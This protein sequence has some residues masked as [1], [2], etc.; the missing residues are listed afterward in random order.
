V[1]DQKHLA[2]LNSIGGQYG[3]ELSELD[4]AGTYFDLK[5]RKVTVNG[6]YHYMCTRNNNFSNRSQKG[7]IVVSNSVATSSVIGSQGGALHAS[8]MTVFV[9]E[10]AFSAGNLFRLVVHPKGTTHTLGSK[11][12]ASSFVEVFFTETPTSPITLDIKYSDDPVG[13]VTAYVSTTGLSGAWSQHAVDND[14]S[15]VAK[16]H[17][18]TPGAY[19]VTTETN[20]AAIIG[21]TVGVLAV[22]IL[23]IIGVIWYFKR[24]GSS[25]SLPT[26]SKA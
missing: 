21:I 20:W 8:G 10:G 5:P 16:V 9:P 25:S 7:K 1:D 14:N 3:G 4:D 24:K 17:I 18:S 19:V 2:I 22:V 11:T 6:I 13:K 26:T 12:I 15:E 23:S